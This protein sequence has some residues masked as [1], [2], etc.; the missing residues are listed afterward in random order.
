MQET[1][2]AGISTIKSTANKLI[3]QIIIF[4]HYI[5]SEQFNLLMTA[6]YSDILREGSS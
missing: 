6:N 3:K 1:G 4:I 5:C 2:A